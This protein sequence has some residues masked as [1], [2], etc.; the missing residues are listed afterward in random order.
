MNS[1][2]ARME[3]I[4]SS[5]APPPSSATG[6]TAGLAPSASS[7]CSLSRRASRMRSCASSAAILDASS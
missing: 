7:R 4:A 5:A 3:R 2:W 1:R 6:V